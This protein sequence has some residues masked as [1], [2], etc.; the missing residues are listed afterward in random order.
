MFSLFIFSVSSCST[1]SILKTTA[2]VFCWLAGAFRT[3]SDAPIKRTECAHQ[4]TT[5]MTDII[6]DCFT[7]ENQLQGFCEACHSVVQLSSD[8]YKAT[9]SNCLREIILNGVD[10]EAQ[11]FTRQK[12]DC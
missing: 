10:L 7:K 8:Y 2:L 4:N 5:T 9:L 6:T 3:G 11:F 1:Y 12:Y